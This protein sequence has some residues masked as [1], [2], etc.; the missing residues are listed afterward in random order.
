MTQQISKL[1]G[2]ALV[3]LISIYGPNFQKHPLF[4][5]TGL[6]FLNLRSWYQDPGTKILVPR[7]W[8]QD[9]GTKI[10]VLRSWYQDLGTKILVKRS[11]YQDPG[12]KMILVPRS[13]HGTARKYL[14]RH[15]S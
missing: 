13:W 14:A 10:L 1:L 9:L 7:S 12:T 5:F 6:W 2:V 15:G 4:Q 11:W 8:Y 3:P